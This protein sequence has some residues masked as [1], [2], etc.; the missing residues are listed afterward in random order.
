MRYGVWIAV[1]GLLCLTACGGQTEQVAEEVE[2]VATVGWQRITPDAM[3]DVQKGQHELSLAAT[4]SLASELMGELMA[5]MDAGGPAEAINVCGSKAPAIAAQI[6]QDYDLAIGRTSHK[7]RNPDNR[8]PE[9]ANVLVEELVDEP[10]Y[11]AGPNGE[12]GA[13]LPI[14]LKKECQICHGPRDQIDETVLATIDESYPEDR[15]VDF[16]EGD[17]RGWFWI[18]V[19]ASRD[20]VG[21]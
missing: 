20:V 11:L 15:A 7:L 4:N 5:G 8:A 1:V 9:W 10:T 13:L 2:P 12:L 21:L 18:E 19:P 6:S 16:A 17:L 14:R 3:T